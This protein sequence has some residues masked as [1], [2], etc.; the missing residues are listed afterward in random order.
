MGGPVLLLTTVGRRSGQFRT[1][2]LLYLEYEA[3][4]VVA[5]S[6]AGDDRHPAW[7]LNLKV[8]PAARIQI[9]GM[10]K[11]VRAR[12]AIEAERSLLWPRF[13]SM[14]SSYEDYRQRTE[15]KIPIVILEPEASESH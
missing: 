13:V 10:V 14:F 12:E 15:R 2:P 5:A 6:Y 1:T 9:K 4:W 8:N 7:W 11:Q 3:N